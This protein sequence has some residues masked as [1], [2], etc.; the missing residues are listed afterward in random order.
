VFGNGHVLVHDLR[1]ALGPRFRIMGPDGF[2]LADTIRLLGA[3][4]EGMTISVPGLPSERLPRQGRAFA[5]A[6]SKAIDAK[7]SPYAIYAGQAAELLVQ[8]IA[9]SDGTRES[10]RKNLFGVRVSGGIL[11]DFSFDANGDTTRNAITIYRIEHGRAVIFDVI[12]PPARLL[13]P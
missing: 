5:A 12:A 10:V 2:T 13:K 9:A 3:D 7:P 11:G 8:A 1:R 4:A 6:F